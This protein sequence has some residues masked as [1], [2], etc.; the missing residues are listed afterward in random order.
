MGRRRAGR[1]RAFRGKAKARVRADEERGCAAE[2]LDYARARRSAGGSL[3]VQ[4][5]VSAR[6]NF[7]LMRWSR[8]F[9]PMLFF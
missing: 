4:I 2:H 8:F 7:S 1:G 9:V 3:E 6:S 5:F